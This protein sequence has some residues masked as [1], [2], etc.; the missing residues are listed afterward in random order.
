VSCGPLVTLFIYVPPAGAM[1]VPVSWC[2]MRCPKSLLEE[3]RKVAKVQSHYIETTGTWSPLDS[4]RLR[5][6]H[7]DHWNVITAGQSPVKVQSH[8]I[9]TT[10]TWSLLDSHRLRH[11]A[12]CIYWTFVISLNKCYELHHC[13]IT[14]IC[15]SVYF[16]PF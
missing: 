6:V 3:P 10:G 8:Y 9:E 11:E 14:I 15:N 7:R 12:A 16:L 5:H 13:L 1:M 2:K 4:H